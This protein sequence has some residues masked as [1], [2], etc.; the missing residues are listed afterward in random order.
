MRK[1]RRSI[2]MKRNYK[3]LKKKG[4]YV[5]INIEEFKY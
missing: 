4:R 2:I 3:T 1:T 5:K